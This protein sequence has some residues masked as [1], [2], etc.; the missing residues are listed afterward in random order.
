MFLGRDA[1]FNEFSEKYMFFIFGGQWQHCGGILQ[2]WSISIGNMNDSEVSGFL[3]EFW[4]I[5]DFAHAK[6]ITKP[7]A[8]NQAFRLEIWMNLKLISPKYMFFIIG[9]QG[10]HSGGILQKSSIS[11]GN[12]NDSEVN[13]FLSECWSILDFGYAKQITKPAI[14]ESSISLGNTNDFDQECDFCVT[15]CD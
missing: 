15:L 2:K 3:N 1:I 13:G 7:G 11:I 4:S 8:Q 5:L 14:Q 9:G 12:I 10:Q 6:Q